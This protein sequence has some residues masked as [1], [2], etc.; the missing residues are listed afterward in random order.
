MGG[1]DDSLVSQRSPGLRVNWKPD[2]L[3]I[4]LGVETQLQDYISSF[5]AAQH[6]NIAPD[7]DD[8]VAMRAILDLASHKNPR[9]RI[10]RRSNMNSPS[11]GLVHFIAYLKLYLVEKVNS[12]SVQ[13]IALTEIDR[14]NITKELICI[15]MLEVEKEFLATR[16]SKEMNLLRRVTDIV[17]DIVWITGAGMMSSNMDPNLTLAS[18]LSHALMLKQPLLRF[19]IL[20]RGR[21]ISNNSSQR[22]AQLTCVNISRALVAHHDSDDKEFIQLEGVLHVSRFVPDTS[23]NTLFRYHLKS[24]FSEPLAKPP[25]AGCIDV[26]I[27]AVGVNAKDIY[28]IMGRVETQEGT[29]ASEFSGIAKSVGSDVDL[30]PGDRVVV[31]APVHFH[32][33]ERVPAWAAYKLLPG[34]SFSEMAPLPVVYTTALY[35]LNDRA[36]L[37]VGESILIHAGA[38][39]FGIATITIAERIG[40]CVYTMVSSLKKR[41]FLVH[42]LGVLETHVFQSRDASF[43][44]NIAKA[45]RGRSVDVVINALVRDLMHESWACMADFGRFVEIGKR[46]LLDAGRLDMRVFL[47]KATFTAFDLGDLYYDEPW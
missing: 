39:A 27:K 32:L 26:A 18:G 31:L 19:S 21:T 20:D 7:A 16:N 46:E 14:V 37:K 35:A 8:D 40:A 30:E 13:T 2:I 4:S 1:D 29:L 25:P 36:H 15:S 44:A 24:E 41:D 45:T 34:E 3:S 11:D 38:R 6:G 12:K 42:E 9:A 10:L 28:T 23:L 33:T 17:S 22:S 43:A 47:R 5:A